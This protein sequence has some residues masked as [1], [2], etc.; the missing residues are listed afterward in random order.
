[1]KKLATVLAV[2]RDEI[3]DLWRR[4]VRE[5]PE[6][7]V[8]NRLPGP[9]L[10]DH[11]PLLLDELAR[12]LEFER[13]GS[14][15]APV[16]HRFGKTVLPKEHARKRLE[17]GYTIEAEVREL[18]LFRVVVL[19]IYFET[20]RGTPPEP[21][22]VRLMH[23]AIDECIAVS[24]A[25]MQR[26]ANRAVA[27]EKALRERFIAVLA[28]DLRSPL[29]NIVMAAEL[30][31]KQGALEP[32]VR[33]LQRILRGTNR[34]ERMIDDLLDFAEARSGQIS[35]RRTPGNLHEICREIADS[36]RAV[37]PDRAIEYLASGDG[38]GEWDAD[39]LAQMV[40]N[41][42]GNALAYGPIQRPVGLRVR[43]LEDSSGEAVIEVHNDG[44]PIAPA[45][46]PH[47]FEPF[48]RG[49]AHVH[50]HGL[51]LGLYIASEI[52]RAHGGS[53]EVRSEEGYGSTFRVRL[54]R[55][56]P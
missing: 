8:A 54:K 41:L 51:G 1:M 56:S 7:P 50:K 30:L 32:Q 4:R 5:D 13:P 23:A 55:W 16:G 40:T 25:E 42:L 2:R 44:R 26:E 39:R 27:S 35:V 53:I 46:L 12:A 47:I 34:I 38:S 22:G 52:A 18:S 17:S 49:S 37:H 31:L 6:V 29:S 36:A 10:E 19:D 14:E 43:D 11:I 33:G 21:T 15:E 28:H 9:V 48:R 3:L 20:L 45:D 24:V